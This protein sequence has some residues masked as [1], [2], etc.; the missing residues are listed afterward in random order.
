ME[1]RNCQ[2]QYTAVF[3]SMNDFIMPLARLAVK[4]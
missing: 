3:R 2:T 4:E 1:E